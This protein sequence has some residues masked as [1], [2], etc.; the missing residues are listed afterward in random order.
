M[1]RSREI[2]QLQDNFVR[3]DNDENNPSDQFYKPLHRD[4]SCA[5]ADKFVEFR[6]N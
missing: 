4:G 5:I 6:S 1:T 3:Q 2:S